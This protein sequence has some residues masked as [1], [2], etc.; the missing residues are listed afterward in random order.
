MKSLF[1]Q[2][3]TL[4]CNARSVG[5]NAL[6]QRLQS[7]SIMLLALFAMSCATN[8]NLI[9]SAAQSQ[10]VRTDSVEKKKVMSLTLAS[11]PKSEA[12]VAIPMENLLN[13][14][15][16]AVFT[17]RKGQA[18]VQVKFVKDTVY[19]GKVQQIKEYIYVTG[20]CDSLQRQ[21]E[22]YENELTRIRGQSVQNE[23]TDTVEQSQTAP[24]ITF[25]GA[26]K[27]C[28]IGII[29]GAILTIITLIIIKR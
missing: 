12:Q 18:T 13:L 2:R 29:I 25:W 1:L 26:F 8:K 4:N 17:D 9:R 3:L 28:S 24:S 27:W 7:V 10:E 20:T 5:L 23:Q 22:Y 14:P 21:C 15:P 16:G 6:C 11:V 19:V